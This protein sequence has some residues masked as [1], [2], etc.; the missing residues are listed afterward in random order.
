MGRRRGGGGGGGN[1]GPG[2]RRATWSTTWSRSRS[3]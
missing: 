3:P 1:G 2:T